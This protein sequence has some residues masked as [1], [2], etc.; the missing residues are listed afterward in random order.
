MVLSAEELTQPVLPV[1][2]GSLAPA[3]PTEK[4][5][6]F[7]A[8]FRGREEIFP[9]RFLSKK[10][11]KAG[12][13]PA[14]AN[15]FVRGVCDLPKVKCTECPNQAF[16]P[17][18]DRVVL[19][20]LQG[21]HVMGV[22]PLLEDE[23]C[24]FLAIDFDKSSWQADIGAFSETCRAMNSPAAIERSRSG[25]G[26]HAWFF[27]RA[28]V[29]ASLAR[30]MGCYL[31]TETMSRRHELSMRSYDRLFPNQDTMPRGGF[32]NL[33]ALP[34][35]YEPR[36]Q[37]NSVFVDPSFQ[38]YDDQWSY[39]ASLPRMMPSF[40]EGLAAE[41]TRRGLVIGVRLAE[42]TDDEEST[43]WRRRPS[44]RP[45]HVPISGPLPREVHAVLAQRLFVEKAN[46]PSPLLNEI[47]R[48]AAFQNPEFY[49]KQSLRLSTAST[50]RV[51]ACAEELPQHVA[52]PR[53]CRS[54][55]ELFLQAH[56]VD[57]NVEDQ[58]QEGEALDVEL[59][60]ELTEVQQQAAAALLQHDIGVFVAPPGIG[61]T[62]LGT[63][64]IAKR[65]RSTLVLVHR[66]PLLDQW[67]AQ[68]SMFL[69][70]EEKEIGQIGGGKRKP[71][72]HL[73]VAMIQSLVRQG[74]V[75]DRVETYGHVIVD[76]CH[77]VPAVS[78]ERVLSEVKARYV[79]GLTATP[80]RRDG[81]HPILEM[82]LGPVRFAVD[83]KNQ[84]AK[85]P[86]EHQLIVRETAFRLEEARTGAGIQGIYSALSG[87][88][89]R[90]R[91]ILDD[92]LHSLDQG[93]SPIL[94]TERRDHL[95]YFAEQLR[96]F[97][98]HLIVLQ[99]GMTT[100]ERRELSARLAAV[101][102][103]EERLVLA[104]GRYIGEGFDDSR[105][106]TLILAMPVSWKGTLVQY[107]GRLH[108]LHPNKSEVRIFDYVDREVPV[109]LRMFEKRLRTYRAIGY[110]RS[111]VFPTEAERI[112]ERTV[113]YDE[114]ALRCFEEPA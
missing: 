93:R 57:L 5:R 75:D 90:N 1:T 20:H 60:G 46:L 95:E 113:E 15:K 73:D 54:D 31:L 81:H 94:L 67:V 99:G 4:V 23:T 3:T 47:K 97:A 36:Q 12:Y 39:L 83:P 74:R 80:H 38:A 8:L 65:A 66:Q 79:V 33:I 112:K 44:G 55:L 64:L 92:V 26:A 48:L 76:E 13:A 32:G 89:V 50:P 107:T 61:K 28:P 88:E 103:G 19:D 87:D 71:N 18:D 110:A 68:L 24:W 84:A 2:T 62:V 34:L 53:G 111:E 108:R 114:E 22:Y 45:R 17:V 7:R 82:Q 91:L 69:G 77:H 100:K 41:A 109:L 78:F 35:Q 86:F 16:T 21:R 11:G 98:R 27:F 70:L 105:L 14:C 9:T 51:I 40:V 37:G 52:L 43:P 104:T 25:N 101:P 96:G 10:T 42:P 102:D 49:K 59:K 30:K 72:G 106:D 85:R 58:R 63:Y 29:A 6:L 56:G